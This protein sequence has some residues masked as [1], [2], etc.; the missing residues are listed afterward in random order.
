MQ[1]VDALIRPRWTA[2]VEPRVAIEERL[3]VAVDRGRIV[4]VVPVEEAERRFATGARHDRPRHVLLPGLVNAH[5]RA[6]TSLFRGLQSDR[7][8]TDTR[9]A[10]AEARWLG[11]ELVAD[12]A[13]LAVAEM[14][15][16]GITCFADAYDYPDIT[17]EVAAETGIRAV[18]G[19]VVRETR[20]AWARDADECVRKGLEV[21]DRFK[22]DPLI[23]TAFALC[24][25][26]DL[27]EATL[28][29]VRQLADELD[30]PVGTRLHETAAE[31]AASVARFGLRPL[32]RLR[33]QGL[34]TP[35][36]IGAHATELEDAEIE[37]LATAGASVAHCPRSNLKQASGV[38]RVEAL[39]RAGVNV[40]LGTDGVD[41][42]DRLDLW[43][44]M[45]TAALLG[46][47]VAGD[48]TAVPAAAALEMATVAGAR[49]LNLE[50]EI[51]SLAPGKAADLICVDLGRLA[52]QPILD[53]LAQLVYA[54]SGEDV[55]DVWIAGAHLVANR[56]LV[57]LD[58][59][60]IAA[61]AEQWGRRLDPGAASG[62]N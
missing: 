10:R 34:V 7:P 48:A 52:L 11:S 57:R 45:R 43:A 53:P 32:A 25:P 40:A 58:A 37:L 13:R 30:V 33:A 28:A 5:V 4:A 20:S 16:G 24:S 14:L 47:H 6:G 38:C 1:R 41:R 23:R 22:G 59:A 60:A 62:D 36:L 3:A 49:A 9:V 44:E 19:M 56:E 17:G 55:T 46:K 27:G 18:L 39:R 54:A 21:H 61:A 31:V 29:R 50:R 42:C 2:R 26:N 51:G 15:L 35:A 8:R 12:G